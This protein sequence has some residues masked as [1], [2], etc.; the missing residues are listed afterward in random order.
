[1]LT[2]QV[3]A[4][5][6]LRIG[7]F[8]TAAHA[9]ADA[10][11]VEDV[12]LE[13]APGNGWIGMALRIRWRG[14]RLDLLAAL[15]ERPGPAEES[16]VRRWGSAA[17]RTD[18]RLAFVLDRREGVEARRERCE[19][20]LLNGREMHDGAGQALIVLDERAPLVRTPVP[21]LAWTVHSSAAGRSRQAGA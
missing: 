15:P 1:V 10:L 19:A 9:T 13:A 20:V 12:P 3:H 4:S 14:G 18:A 17:L 8:I 21:S 11:T 2:S 7:T 6:P 5:L 16:P